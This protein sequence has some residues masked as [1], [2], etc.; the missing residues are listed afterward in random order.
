[1]MVASAPYRKAL[2]FAEPHEK[3]G[4]QADGDRPHDAVPAYVER[5]YPDERGVETPDYG[6]KLGEHVVFV[7]V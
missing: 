4:A 1:M 5:A 6:E 3:E 2:P 7:L